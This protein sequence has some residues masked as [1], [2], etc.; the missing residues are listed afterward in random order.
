[1]GAG[2]AFVHIVNY[3]LALTDLV[4]ETHFALL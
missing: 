1:M 4:L 2:K 3:M